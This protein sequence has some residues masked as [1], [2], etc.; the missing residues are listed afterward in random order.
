MSFFPRSIESCEIVGEKVVLLWEPESFQLEKC[1][2]NLT[3]VNIDINRNPTL[4]VGVFTYFGRGL[5]C[6]RRTVRWDWR[7][8]PA[9]YNNR[10]FAFRPGLIDHAIWTE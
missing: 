10:N 2:S 1:A 3:G 5:R 8:I 7:S 4:F 9:G 6:G